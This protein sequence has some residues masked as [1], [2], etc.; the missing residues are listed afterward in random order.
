MTI[1]ATR[2]Q[3][4][5]NRIAAAAHAAGRPAGDI[6]LIAVSKTFPPGAIADAFA[7]GQ[8][9]FGESYLQE[10]IPKIAA[11]PD[12]AYE[13]HYIGPIQSN[14][15]KQIAELFDWAHGIDRLKVAERLSTARP[16]GARPLDICIQVNISGELSKSGVPPQEVL[17]LARAVHGLP[18][19]RL[20][21]LMGIP[22]PDS[23]ASLMRARFRQIREL[24]DDI[25]AAGIAMDTLSMGMSDDLEAAIAEGAT[26]V[27]VGRAI[28]GDRPAPPR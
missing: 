1:I 24:R 11:L 9:A 27:R 28:F 7:V 22:E 5:R 14:K 19:I 20:R 8:T 25:I 16:E 23:N 18:G 2:L 12:S 6:Q 4:V 13:W 10:A 26:M 3:A 15:T 17:S 21:G